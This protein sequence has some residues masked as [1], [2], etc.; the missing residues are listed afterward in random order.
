MGFHEE[1]EA[2]V[3]RHA[4]LRKGER[5]RRLAEGHGHAEKL[6]LQQVWWPAVGHFDYLHPEYEVVDFKDGSRFLDFAYVRNGERVAIEIDGFGPHFRDASRQQFADQLIRQNHL[7]LDGWHV[8]RFA[9]DDVKDK[10]RRCQQ[11][12]QQFIGRWYGADRPFKIEGLSLYEQEL[13]RLAARNPQPI[14]PA[15]AAARLGVSDRYA[16]TLLHSLAQRAILIPAAGR[17][18]IR[19]YRLHPNARQSGTPL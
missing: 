9:Y 10:P 14:T 7:V 5:L 3:S 18:R 11:I 17:L 16:R 4:Q 12:V 2:Y 6:F 8:I 1:Y 13:M 19:A 15:D